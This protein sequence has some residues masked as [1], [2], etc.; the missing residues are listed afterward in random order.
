MS[1]SATHPSLL[2]GLRRQDPPSW[3]RLVDLFGPLVFAMCKRNGLTSEAAADVMQETF[4]SVSQSLEKFRYR[5][6]DDTFRGWLT[7]I[8]Q[9]RIADFHRRRTAVLSA[10]GGSA[11]DRMLDAAVADADRSESGDECT[12]EKELEGLVRRA[13]A[14]IQSEVEPRSWKAFW[15]TTVNGMTAPA[16]A[17]ELGMQ[18]AAVRKAKSRVARRL[19]ELLGEVDD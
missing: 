13:A 2:S 4:L 18:P 11:A 12:H 14:M 3:E 19:R 17:K 1:S 6:S 16:A 9:H 5:D 15:L 7:R 8:A 10:V